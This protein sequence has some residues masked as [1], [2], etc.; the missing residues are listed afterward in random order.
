MHLYRLS[1]IVHRQS[2][3]HLIE[4]RYMNKHRTLALIALL[5][6][7]VVASFAPAAAASGPPQGTQ[8]DAA[9][10]SSYQA[11]GVTNVSATTQRT[12]CYAPEL[13]YFGALTLDDGY[14]D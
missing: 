2:V 4:D 3:L 8:T 12:S 1:S 7:L 10:V 6:A 13:T 9:F 14:L 5:A 11:N